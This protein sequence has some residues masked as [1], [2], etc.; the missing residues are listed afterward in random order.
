MG[1]KV[2]IGENVDERERW[3]AQSFVCVRVW[4]RAIIYTFVNLPCVFGNC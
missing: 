3:E 1:A 4:L 2:D